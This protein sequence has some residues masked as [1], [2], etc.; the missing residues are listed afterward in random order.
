MQVNASRPLSAAGRDTLSVNGERRTKRRRC[1]SQARG[2]AGMP[3]M[4]RGV[5]TG[6]DDGASRAVTSAKMR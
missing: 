2:G 4:A 1:I 3:E 5:R 6:R